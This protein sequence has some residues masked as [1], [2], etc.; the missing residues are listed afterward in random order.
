MSLSECKKCGGHI[1]L[2]PDASNR[3]DK[4]GE[5]VMGS[6]PTMEP[7]PVQR[8]V[9]RYII[10]KGSISGHCCFDFSVLDTTKPHII[11]GKHYEDENGKHYDVVCE[12]FY[13]ESAVLICNLLNAPV[14]QQKKMI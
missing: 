9:G 13:E 10:M 12:C 11:G 1:P 3:C 6:P 7:S 2:G 4:C 5:H 14:D 8:L